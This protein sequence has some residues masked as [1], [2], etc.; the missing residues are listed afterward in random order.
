MSIKRGLLLLLFIV[1]KCAYS[2]QNEA[3]KLTFKSYFGD[4]EFK[5][6][7]N[8]PQSTLNDSI[9][10]ETLKFYISGI[11]LLDSNNR[12]WKEKN[13]YHLIDFEDKNSQTIQLY[14]PKK[15]RISNLKFNIG[16]DS[17][18]SNSGALDGDLDPT[19]GMYWAWQSGYIN[20]KMEGTSPICETRKH[21]FQ[22][23]LGGY[24]K[25]FYA[26]QSITLPISLVEDNTVQIN[27]NIAPI[28]NSISLKDTYSIM[29]PCREALELSK[30]VAK[31]F[32]IHAH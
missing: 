12:I 3:I 13:S 20:F 15:S 9:Q 16:I 10:I 19:K 24:M 28:F 18:T 21:K 6:N 31:L 5:L 22:F 4:E 8:Y 26:M 2:Q 25:P 30:I 27:F 17:I 32:S 11:E 14:I 1:F 7:R 23:H 29:I